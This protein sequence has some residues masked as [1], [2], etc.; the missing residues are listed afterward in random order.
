MLRMYLDARIG[1]LIDADEEKN[2]T[3]IIREYT[4]SSN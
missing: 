1:R 2:K 4:F 3:F